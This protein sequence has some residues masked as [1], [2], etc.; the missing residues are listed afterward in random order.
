MHLRRML[1]RS[2]TQRQLIMTT[3]AYSSQTKIF[4]WLTALLIIAIIP[5]G[6]IAGQLPIDTDAQ[7]ATKTMLFSL[8][9]TLGVTV[10]IVALARI[11]YALTQ[12]K[13]A[14]LHPERKLETLLAEVVHWLLYISLVAVPLSGWIHH[15]AAAIA[16]PIWI[17]FAQSLPFV[18]TD[19]TVS[20]FFRGLHWLWSKIMVAS[21]LLHFAGAMKHH[22]IDKDDTLRRMWWVNNVYVSHKK[23][24]S[25]FPPIIAAGIFVVVAAIGA[26]AGILSHEK[27]DAPALAAVASDWRVT[28]GTIGITVK[29]LGN[30]VSGSFDDWVSVIIFDETADTDAGSVQTTINIAS[31]SLGSVTSQAMGRDFFDQGQ[32]PNAVFAADL[33]REGGTYVADGT[34]SIK[35]ITVPVSMPFAVSV[36]DNTAT[37]TGTV[38]LDRRDF[39]IGESMMDEGNLGFMVTVQISLAATRE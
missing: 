14:G 10:F 5:L 17:P 39:T 35:G 8:H 26:G 9:K 21:I 32:F 15:S 19:P 33:I 24:I 30:D 20:D 1:I 13:P 37:M 29:Q 22:F 38:Q 34:L 27:S 6:V 12:S 11:G 25:Y 18:P 31:L 7:V 28:D 2:K 3:T 36:D 16:A 4:H 23:S